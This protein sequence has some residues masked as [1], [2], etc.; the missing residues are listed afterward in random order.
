MGWPDWTGRT[1]AIIASGPSAKAAGVDLL[2][3][4]MPVVAIKRCV[5]L[6]P[7]AD[8]VY[9]CDFPWWRSVRGLPDFH[10]EKWSYAPQACDQYGARQVKIDRD[11]NDLLFGEVGFVGSGGNSGFHALNLVAQ[12]GATRILLVGFDVHD[13]GGVHW[14]GRNIA[15]GMSN[16]MEHNFRRWRGAFETA[17]AQ[18]KARGV[19]VINA[20]PMSDIKG[21]PRT[22]LRQALEAWGLLE[23][24]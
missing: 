15:L 22:T 8:A 7:W 18:L 24:A 5:E 19:E 20:S 17:S 16:P 11:R 2:K 3:G 9:G 13:R 4:R 6:A 1:V 14:Y 21:F 12:F 10:G 23:T